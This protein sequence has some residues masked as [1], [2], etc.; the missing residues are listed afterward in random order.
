MTFAV[1]ASLHMTPEKAI[2]DAF[3]I[4]HLEIGEAVLAPVHTVFLKRESLIPYKAAATGVLPELRRI[5]GRF[6]SQVKEKCL[7][8][9]AF[10]KDISSEQRSQRKYLRSASSPAPKK[11]GFYCAV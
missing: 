5:V 10:F 11:R 8:N 2:R 4:G 1:H 6:E 7:A 9:L 3:D